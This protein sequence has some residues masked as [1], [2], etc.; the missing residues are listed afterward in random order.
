MS[1]LSRC[2]DCGA[3]VSKKASSCPHCG[4]PI[5]KARKSLIS[6]CGWLLAILFGLGA[7]SS[8]LAPRPK[9]V[10][11]AAPAAD[12][13][14]IARAKADD[15]ASK[16]SREAA[17]AQEKERAS[18]NLASFMDA[19]KS[20][21]IANSVVQSVSVDRNRATITVVNGWHTTAYQI[22]LQT[23]QN[24]W[25]TWAT[26]ASP[27]NVDAAR[28][29]IVDL[30]GNEVGGSRAIAGSLIWVQDK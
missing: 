14:Q 9:A 20:G 28:I 10:P 6:G 5:A 22:R 21:G 30:R 29:S 12:P 18:K 19:I 7:V 11:S 17:A 1:N 13:E 24:L 23:A 4:S 8:F 26:I 3:S 15:L 27:Q 2:R 25:E 16:E